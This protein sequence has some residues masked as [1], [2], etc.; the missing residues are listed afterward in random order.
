MNAK[1]III[2]LML[3]AFLFAA[4]SSANEKM[5]YKNPTGKE[6]PILAW[7]SILGDKN[8]TKER[9]Q[10]LRE[11]GFNI[12]FNHFGTAAELEKGLAACK[13]TGV[14][15]MATCG[16]L[17]SNTEATVK[18]FKGDP[19]IAGW[20][21]RD[22]PV[23][24]GFAELRKFRDRI[25]SADKSHLMYL[26][27][28]PIMV[29]PKDLL[30]ESYE[31]YVQRFVD[32]VNITPI[33]YDM[34]PVVTENGKPV[35]RQAFFENF[36]VARKVS[37]KCG[38]PFWAFCLST[39]HTP[40]PIPSDAHLRIEAFSALA[41]GAQCIQYFTY[42]TPDTTTWNFHNAPIDENGKRTDVYYRVKELNKE[43]HAL[44]KVFLG[45]EATDVR[46]TG[47]SIP[48]GTKALT[49]MP[50]K[51]QSLQ[52]DGEGIL[53]SQ[54]ANGKSRYVMLLNRSIY[55]TQN[56]T[57]YLGESVKRIT[58]FNGE[59]KLNVGRQTVTLTPGNYAI[60]KIK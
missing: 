18:R 3:T 23:T 26:N 33:S 48:P 39:A 51:F 22:E 54:L 47:D 40:Y 12:S 32:E 57:F 16:E 19:S 9:Y 38:Y 27:L 1:K 41:Y 17:V 25:Y 7:Y 44:T 34:Y 37:L 49:Q 56:I 58:P 60:Y 46:H 6:F 2:P 4:P 31:D 10:E 55:N 30:A 15:I 11:A 20:F 21:L 45:A 53:V 35:L 13:G 28:L 50:D 52:S 36:E 5:K 59:E 8:Q 24:S 43:I 14:K 29:A 42:W